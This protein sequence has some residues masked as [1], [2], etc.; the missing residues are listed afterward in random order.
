MLHDSK[1]VVGVEFEKTKR[2]VDGKLVGTEDFF[3]VECD[4]VFKAIGQV[5]IPADLGDAPEHLTFSK[6]KVVVN[7]RMQTS[8]PNVFAGGDCI[9]GGA[10]TVNAVQDGKVAARAMHEFMMG[11]KAHG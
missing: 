4:T 8:I 3:L 6:G 10:L 9:N 7:S 2:G 11:E 5:L 1:G